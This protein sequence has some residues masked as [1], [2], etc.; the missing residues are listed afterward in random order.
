M[1]KGIGASLGIG[2]GYAVVIKEAE[3]NIGQRSIEDTAAEMAVFNAALDKTKQKSI[4]AHIIA[5]PP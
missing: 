4:Y 2:M 1:L 5:L 3:L